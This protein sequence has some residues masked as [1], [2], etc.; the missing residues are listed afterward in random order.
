MSIAYERSVELITDLV[1]SQGCTMIIAESEARV[2]ACIE[3]IY[4]DS[5][6][7]CVT[8]A[9]NNKHLNPCDIL[10]HAE[11]LNKTS[12]PVICFMTHPADASAS[13][14]LLANNGGH[15]KIHVIIMVW[16]LNKQ[17]VST[18]GEY[19]DYFLVQN[20]TRAS[21]HARLAC[22]KR[23]SDESTASDM[24]RQKNVFICLK[25]N[26]MGINSAKHMDYLPLPT[27]YQSLKAIA[28]PCTKIYLF[29]TLITIVIDY[30]NPVLIKVH[31]NNNAFQFDLKTY[32]WTPSHDAN[33]VPLQ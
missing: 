8:I 13:M 29:E 23:C 25:F 22:R 28:I 31:A 19:V 6:Q 32:A 17:I 20:L 10:K 33:S 18:M 2:R 7:V 1:K 11:Q 24:L 27:S 3:T 12:L 14:Q 26:S 21:I 30:L 16:E 5:A 9:D 4:T 15:T